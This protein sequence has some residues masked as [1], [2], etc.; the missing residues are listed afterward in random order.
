LKV[1]GIFGHVGQPATVVYNQMG[2][3]RSISARK[4]SRRVSFFLAA[5][6]RSEKLFCM[7][8]DWSVVDVA[9][10]SQIMPPSETGPDE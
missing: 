5:Y 6:S 2:V 1:N 3:A 8:V 7:M 10:L 9:L 4:R